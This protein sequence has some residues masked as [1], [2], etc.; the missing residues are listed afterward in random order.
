[1]KAHQLADLTAWQ[2]RLAGSVQRVA[3]K[4]SARVA[5]LLSADD[6]P[7]DGPWRQAVAAMVAGSDCRHLLPASR[8]ADTLAQVGQQQSDLPPVG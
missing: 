4:K 6:L 1:M 2:D 8:H 3:A 5:L 7:Q